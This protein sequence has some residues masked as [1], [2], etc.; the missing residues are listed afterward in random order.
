M[1]PAASFPDTLM[2]VQV[3]QLRIYG[4][5]SVHQ[6]RNEMRHMLLVYIFKAIISRFFVYKGIVAICPD[7][8]LD[9]VNNNICLSLDLVIPGFSRQ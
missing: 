4:L 7:A 3:I 6:A 2:L 9:E 8:S 1:L 5:R